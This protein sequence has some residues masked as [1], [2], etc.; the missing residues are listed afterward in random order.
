[1]YHPIAFERKEFRKTLI[2]DRPGECDLL[3]KMRRT[4]RN[5][6]GEETSLKLDQFRRG[7]GA[8]LVV[9]SHV[10]DASAYWIASHDL[11]PVR[12][13][14][15]GRRAGILHSWIEP[16]VVAIRIKNDR[17]AIMDS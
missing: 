1:M 6:L 5:R 9:I 2:I 17:H 11:C 14:H 3:S 12:F 7:C 13:Q 10:I 8:I 15:F 4:L 16:Q